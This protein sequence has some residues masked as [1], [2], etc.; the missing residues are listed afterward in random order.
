MDK[1]KSIMWIVGAVA[2]AYLIITPLM[3][4][5]STLSTDASA[6]V[7]TSPYIDTYV[8]AQEGVKYAPWIL[9]LSPAVIGIGG[10]VW[11]LKKG[12]NGA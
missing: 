12:S 6:E 9:Y 3:G 2:L 10:V 4:F 7:G 11:V 8:G 1:V 5:I